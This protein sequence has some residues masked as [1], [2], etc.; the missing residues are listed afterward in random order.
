M[1]DARAARN[2][3]FERDGVLVVRGALGPSALEAA[4]AAYDWSLAHPGPRASRIAQVGEAVFYND[5]D[6]PDWLPADAAFFPSASAGGR[7]V[8]LERRVVHV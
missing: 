5:L 7:S 3:V 1:R 6:N 2:E 8:G 4:L